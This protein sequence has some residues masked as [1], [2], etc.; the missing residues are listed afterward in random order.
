V[1]NKS[2]QDLE[3]YCESPASQ[4]FRNNLFLTNGTT[5]EFAG[6]TCALKK[7]THQSLPLNQSS[8]IHIWRQNFSNPSTHQ[9]IDAL[10]GA[11][12]LRSGSCYKLRDSSF[13][14]YKSGLRSSRSAKGK[15]FSK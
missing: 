5:F 9:P 2:G 14:Q 12:A 11:L 6:S 8:H 15:D 3:D 7:L 13:V 1:V 10:A 4:D